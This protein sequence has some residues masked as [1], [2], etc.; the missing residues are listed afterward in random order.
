MLVRNS[1]A[2]AVNS[3]ATPRI[4]VMIRETSGEGVPI[5]ASTSNAAKAAGRLPL[6]SSRT[7]CQ[8]IVPLARCTLVPTVLVTVANRRSVPTA[9]VG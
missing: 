7:I 1:T 3:K 5:Q 8:S 2:I 9:V 4:V 6:A